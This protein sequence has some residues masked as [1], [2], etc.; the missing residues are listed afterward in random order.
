MAQEGNG[1]GG[2]CRHDYLFISAHCNQSVA[3]R[4]GRPVNGR[5]PSD[6]TYTRRDIMRCR[7]CLADSVIGME[8]TKPTEEPA[9]Y[10]YIP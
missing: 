3:S 6:T 8:E 2:G 1:G 7:H 10:W 5:P 9:P 4:V